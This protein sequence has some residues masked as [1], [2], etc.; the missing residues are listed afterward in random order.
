M[1]LSWIE[2]KDTCS[3]SSWDY[4]YPKEKMDLSFFL[5]CLSPTTASKLEEHINY[6]SYW[7]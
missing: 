4:L 1:F 2:M 6:L 5:S 3:F 7:S